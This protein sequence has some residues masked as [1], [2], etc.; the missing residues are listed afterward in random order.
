MNPE[1]R[2]QLYGGEISD[3]YLIKNKNISPEKDYKNINDLYQQI[4]NKNNTLN[5]PD[6]IKNKITFIK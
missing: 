6:Q 4:L 1:T 5:L 2:Q 3:Y